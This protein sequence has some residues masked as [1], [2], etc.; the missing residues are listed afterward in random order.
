LEA[1]KEGKR[2]R[3]RQKLKMLDWIIG[4]FRVKDG[5]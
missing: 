4:R 5:K 2:A 1:E 3:G